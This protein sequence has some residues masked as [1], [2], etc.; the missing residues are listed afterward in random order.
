MMSGSK[1]SKLTESLARHILDSRKQVTILF[2][3]I[4]Y[5]TLH[6]DLLGDVDGRL[7]VDQHNRLL[8]PV[9]KKFRGK[10]IK[11]IGDA[12]MASFKHPENAVK[13]AIGIQQILY[14]SR[15]Q[16]SDFGFKVRI[17]IHTGTGIVEH[18]D[19][20]GDVVNVAAHLQSLSKGDEI[21]ISGNTAARLDRLDFDLSERQ[22]FVPKGKQQ[23]IA[24]YKCD[25]RSH[26][27]IVEDIQ[28]NSFLPLSLRDRIDILIFAA[29]SLVL[30]YFIYLRYLR[31][32]L[33]DYESYALFSLNPRL[34]L[35]AHPIIP[36]TLAAI[37]VVAG[38]LVINVR[39]VP[40][41][42]LRL[43]KGGFGFCIGFF[44]FYLP[45]VL[46]PV[47]FDSFWSESLF[48]SQH[49]FVE[50]LEDNTSLY[51]QPSTAAPV[52]RTVNAG[53]LL[54]LTDIAERG[55]MSWN[56]VL[57][58]RGDYAWVPRKLPPKIGVPEKRLTVTEKFYFKF[59]DLYALLMG[60]VGF[61]WGVVSFRIRPI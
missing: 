31:Y 41:T 26:Y 22:G 39:S 53:T 1:S 14:H 13:A 44:L 48:Q 33:A 50:A 21:L 51:A 24:V 35:E 58:G 27:N 19:I 11:T 59:R 8:F 45:A 34:F 38:L 47:D 29:S 60:L 57:I 20:Y 5:S 23:E 17:G 55:L 3:D 32:L 61:V 2:T 30:L 46:L 40:L 7:M 28:P 18:H 37:A 12:I 9:I 56:K 49:L 43:L 6:W 36:A 16:Q 42:T 25:W 52:V 10:V 15:H 4:E 54:L